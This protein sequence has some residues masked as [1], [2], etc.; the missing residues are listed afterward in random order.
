MLFV[1]ALITVL[2]KPGDL[3][4]NDWWLGEGRNGREEDEEEEGR[5]GGRVKIS[6]L[7]RSGSDD[8]FHGVSGV[9][10][11]PP[12]AGGKPSC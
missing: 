2:L 3:D 8:V 6:D 11:G 5:G 4:Q 12:S 10:C 1:S 9:E 7:F